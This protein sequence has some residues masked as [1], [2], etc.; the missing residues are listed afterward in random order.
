MDFYPSNSPG[1]ESK[2]G[3]WIRLR[4]W[5]P[6]TPANLTGTAR[7]E[8]LGIIRVSAEYFDTL[9]VQPHLGRWFRE[10]EEQSGAPKV[11]ILTD[12]GLFGGAPFPPGRTS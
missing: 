3:R 11:A 12:L 4:S 10:S 7:P 1:G 8:K 5:P 2:P 6:G 9:R